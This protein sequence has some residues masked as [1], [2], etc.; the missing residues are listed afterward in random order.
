[1]S[2][3]YKILDQDQLY[4]VTFT[5]I[6]WLDVFTRREYRDIFMDSLR[7]CQQY[8]GLNLYAYCIMTNHVH[9]IIGRR[10]TGDLQGIIRDIKKYTSV[11]IIEAV[12]DNPQESRKDLLMW[13]FERTG[14]YNPNNKIYQFWEQHSHPIELNTNIMLEQRLEY[15]HNNPVKAGIVLSPED[16]L[17]SS[18]INYAGL[19]EKLIDVILI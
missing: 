14:R 2:R 4:F 3:K 11:K 19:P 15:I 16:Y 9:M 17:Y 1:M 5:V 10:G 13:M 7:Y 12:K 8:K 6:R 18:A